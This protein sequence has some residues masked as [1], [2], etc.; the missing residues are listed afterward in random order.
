MEFANS[1]G[2]AHRVEIVVESKQ[3]FTFVESLV[4]C[5]EGGMLR[6]D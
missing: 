6:Q 4:N 3:M 1:L 2:K 5:C